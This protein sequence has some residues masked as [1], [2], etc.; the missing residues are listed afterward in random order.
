MPI[1]PNQQESAV[2]PLTTLIFLIDTSGSM[3]GDRI[4]AVNAAMREAIPV[5]RDFMEENSDSALRYNVLEFN[6]SAKWMTENPGLIED[7]QW[8]D[9]QAG[10]LTALGAAYSELN[11]K[12]SRKNGFLQAHQNN[13]PIIILLSDGGATDVPNAALS[14]LKEN[15]WFKHAIRIAVEFGNDC[16]HDELLAFTGS[17]EGI[18]PV[19]SPSELKK[20]LRVVAVQSAMIG[21]KSR[22]ANSRSTK[23]EI[24][25]KVEEDG[26]EVGEAKPTDPEPPVD[27]NSTSGTDDGVDVFDGIFD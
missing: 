22:G 19:D 3:S 9:L 5:V 4:Q 7:F 13:A 18:I 27:P 24:L 6:T 17:S 2:L 15:A 23:K 8:I 16:D 1:N 21:S 20:L 14:E 10:G 11:K 12:L 26:F 25:D